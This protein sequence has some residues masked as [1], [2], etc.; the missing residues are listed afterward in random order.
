M[1]VAV[2][3]IL[4]VLAAAAAAARIA[5]GRSAPF[6]TVA[7]L[8]PL[9]ALLAL[10]AAVV[11]IAV[12][13]WPGL[14]LA[15]P[16]AVLVAWQLPG[17]RPRERPRQEQA[18]IRI[19]SINALVGRASPAAIL[20]E[21]E[22]FSADLLVVQELTPELTEPL[23]RELAELLPYSSLHP[24]PG[25]SGIGVWSRWPLTELSPVPG[26]NTLMPR[27]Q[28]QREW[29]VTL[30]PVHTAAPLTL[31][32]SQWQHDFAQ[33]LSAVAAT[34]GHQLVVGDFNATRDHRAFRKLLSAGLG[35]CADIARSRPWPGFTWPADR[36]Y[37][38]LIRLDHILVS[39]PGALVRQAR[40]IR[41]PGT[42]HLGV[43]AVIDLLPLPGAGSEE[44]S[45]ASTDTR[46]DLDE[47]A[48]QDAT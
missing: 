26:T 29:P 16:T 34:P 21:S 39:Q 4:A 13:G 18:E 19:V 22:A 15:A 48:D 45:D 40:T 11:S 10:V 38:P 14:I 47:T 25:S 6:T 5:P 3:V 20:A 8:S 43:L 46:P 24:S 35:D 36:R 23:A 31:R 32:H 37:P 12:T 42:D 41:V 2:M 1:T 28:V 44:V 30:T 7:A 17:R 9:I 33:L 27:V